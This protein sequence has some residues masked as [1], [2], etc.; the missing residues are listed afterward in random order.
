MKYQQYKFGEVVVWQENG[1]LIDAWLDNGGMAVPISEDE[2]PLPPEKFAAKLLEEK[3]QGKYRCT[4]CRGTFTGVPAGYPIFAG[5]NCPEC[6]KEHQRVVESQ[7]VSGN[8]CRLC[9]SPRAVC[10]C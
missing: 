5:V 4:R 9:G 8:V 10:T 2:A 1:R 7:L 6:W 3:G